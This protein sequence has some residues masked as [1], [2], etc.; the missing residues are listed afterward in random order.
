[1]R[2]AYQRVE[3]NRLRKK[4]RGLGS[5][6]VNL[7][8]GRSPSEAQ[9]RSGRLAL[10]LKHLK[11]NSRSSYTLSSSLNS[12]TYVALYI[13]ICLLSSTAPDTKPVLARYPEG[14]MLCWYTYH[15]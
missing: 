5:I 7:A 4:E 1:M 11:K 9:R 15:E 6:C 12:F 8:S 3:T 14:C 13:K 2:L 10:H